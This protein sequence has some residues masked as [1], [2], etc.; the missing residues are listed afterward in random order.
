MLTSAS[1]GIY[2]TPLQ[3]TSCSY[4][5]IDAFHLVVFVPIQ[6]VRHRPHPCRRIFYIL[7]PSIESAHLQ[8]LHSLLSFSL[9]LPRL[10]FA[11]FTLGAEAKSDRV[12]PSF[13]HR[14]K[15]GKHNTSPDAS[16]EVPERTLKDTSKEANLHGRQCP[17]SCVFRNSVSQAFIRRA[18]DVV[19]ATVLHLRH[20]G[21]L[22]LGIAAVLPPLSRTHIL[23]HISAPI[24]K[25]DGDNQL[26]R[27]W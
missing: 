21:N 3:T 8:E 20:A 18:P 27:K 25:H 17:S 13:R 10:L 22:A 19:P 26:F 6:T 15:S 2:P 12:A 1:A 14:G 24:I 11:R 4:Q 5:H 23:Y 16:D 9:I 7:R